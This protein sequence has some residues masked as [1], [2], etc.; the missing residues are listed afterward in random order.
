MAAADRPEDLI[1]Q[2]LIDID[3]DE[4]YQPSEEPDQQQTSR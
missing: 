3:S 1:R 2:L 4:E